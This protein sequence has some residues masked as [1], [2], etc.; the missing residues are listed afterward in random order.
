MEAVLSIILGFTNCRYG[1]LFYHRWFYLILFLLSN[2]VK[3]QSYD[4]SMK[5]Y[6]VC[7]V[8]IKYGCSVVNV[9]PISASCSVV[10]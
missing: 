3:Y 1:I 2:K 9:R 8:N 10:G 4:N 6:T 7:Y 5:Q